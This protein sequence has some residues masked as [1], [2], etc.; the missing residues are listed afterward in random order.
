LN[1]KRNLIIGMGFWIA[2]MFALAAPAEARTLLVTDSPTTSVIRIDLST[3]MP[4]GSPIPVGAFPT[5]IAIT[6]SGDRALVSN[7]NGNTISEFDPATGNA[8]GNPIAIDSPSWIAI[9]PDGTRAYVSSRSNPEVRVLDLI[10]NVLLQSPIAIQGPGD[11]VFSPDGARAYIAETP[12]PGPPA[13]AVAVVNTANNSLIGSPITVPAA[14]GSGMA[15]TPDGRHIYVTTAANDS[16]TVID[17]ATN[18]AVGGQISVGDNP[19]DIAI[20]PD[21]RRAYVINGLSNNVSIIDTASNS[22]VATIPVGSFPREATVTPDGG[23]VIVTSDAGLSAIDTTTNAVTPI[24]AGNGSLDVRAVPNQGPTAAFTSASAVAGSP[25]SFDAS[26]SSDPDGSVAHYSWEFGDGSTLADA[27]ATPAHTYAVAGTYTVK[28]T[29]TDNEGCSTQ[30]VFTGQ[31]AS[32]NGKP[33]AATQSQVTV[34]PDS[35]APTVKIGKLK[36]KYE[37]SKVKITFTSSEPGSTFAC[38]LDKKKAK[39]CSSPVTYKHL[40]PGKHIFRLSAVD[41]AGNQ[42]QASKAKFKVAD[43]G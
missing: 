2:A 37:T 9:S 3:N 16:V 32:C 10:N 42:S 6:P 31:T 28:L 24:Q 17:T 39:G 40:K 15:I 38:K 30:F 4:F 35:T 23:R 20:T 5:H 34:A 1:G 27:G 25:T 8:I 36:K 22:V 18:S 43:A 19:R 7:D 21:G 26:G 33:V 13:A 14:G 11:V 41:A 29:T 12:N